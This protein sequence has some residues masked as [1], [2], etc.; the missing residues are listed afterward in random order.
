MRI[1]P[2]TGRFLPWLLASALV[3][4]V[5][6]GLFLAVS[7]L[8]FVRVVGLSTVAVGAGLTI[9]ALAAMPAVLPV[10][11]RRLPSCP[12]SPRGA[13]PMRAAGSGRFPIV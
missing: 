13:M 10:G 1:R 12:S 9:A 6:T 11:W 8:F 2:A 4:W 7:V 3:D 5:G